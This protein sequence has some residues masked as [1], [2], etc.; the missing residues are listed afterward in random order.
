MQ[1]P[2]MGMM[3][4]PMMMPQVPYKQPTKVTAIDTDLSPNDEIE[5]ETDEEPFKAEDLGEIADALKAFGVS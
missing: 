1:M 5:D 2:Q 3:I 4:Q